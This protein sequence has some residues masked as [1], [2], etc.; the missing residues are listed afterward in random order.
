M[1]L[2]FDHFAQ[3]EAAPIALRQAQAK[4]RNLTGK[5]FAEQYRPEL[6]AYLNRIQAETNQQ[7]VNDQRTLLIWLGQQDYP[8]ASPYYWAGFSLYGSGH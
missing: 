7:K 3:S 8:F 4:L 5:E 6:E 1:T 2:F